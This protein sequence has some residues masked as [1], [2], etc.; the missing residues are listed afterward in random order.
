MP[1][2]EA[3][4]ATSQGLV[5][6]LHGI[7]GPHPGFRPGRAALLCPLS[8][9]VQG[10]MC[11]SAHAK[12]VLLNGVF[13]PTE[14]AALLSTAP[15]FT[16]PETRVTARFSSS[17]G[18]PE[19]PDSDPN[20]NPRGFAVRFN[21][22]ETPRRVH[23]DIIAHSTPFFPAPNGSEALAFFKSVAD[24]SIG[25]YLGT[26]PSAL[27]FVQTPKPTPA[28]FGKEKYFSVNAFKLVAADGK[29]TYIRYRWVPSAGEEY[30][31]EAALKDK[32]PDFLFDGV[33]K[34]LEEGPIV[35]KLMAQVAAPGDVTDDCTVHWPDD[36]EVAEL[37]ALTLTGMVEEGAAQQ[38]I[39]I[40]DPIPRVAGIEPSGDPLLQVRA[41]VYLISGKERR[42]A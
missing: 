39:I 8:M 11:R 7:F 17:T 21:I 16:R 38:K 24:G 30:L 6:T 40:F 1:K 33:A 2:D 3:I 35:F 34:S 20:G 29:D 26:H 19:L 37:G 31:D 10:L 42:A 36:R 18:I 28:S 14:T 41:G 27:A 32:S 13:K 12:G 4:V 25:A 15:H 9:L 5:D 22:E 23:T